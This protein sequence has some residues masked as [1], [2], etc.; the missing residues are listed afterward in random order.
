MDY[1]T[2]LGVRKRKGRSGAAMPSSVTA[3]EVRRIL[4]PVLDVACPLCHKPPGAPCRN[5]EGEVYWEQHRLRQAA[6]RTTPPAN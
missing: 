1:L 4:G 2:Y 3:A 5:D 6:A